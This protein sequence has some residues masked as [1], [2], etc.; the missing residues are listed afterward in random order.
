[1]KNV[2]GLVFRQSDARIFSM[3]IMN[4]INEYHTFYSTVTHLTGPFLCSTGQRLIS[5]DNSETS[6]LVHWGTNGAIGATEENY[7]LGE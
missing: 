5:T 7:V 1:M 6:I 3:Y 4:L 2:I